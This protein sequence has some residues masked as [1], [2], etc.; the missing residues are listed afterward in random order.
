MQGTVK[1]FDEVTRSGA[2][3]LDDGTEIPIPP[4]AFSRSGLLKL[5]FGQ[6]VRFEVA[7][8]GD[9]RR[10]TSITIATLY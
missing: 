9:D 10:V 4:E 3:I 6:R 1:E 2:V 8:D 7:G 5:Q